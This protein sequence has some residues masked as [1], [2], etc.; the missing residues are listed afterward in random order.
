VRKRAPTLT[1]IAKTMGTSRPTV[2]QRIKRLAEF[3]WVER[4]VA[5]RTKELAG[6]WRPRDVFVVVLDHETTRR[7][8][9]A[10]AAQ[11]AAPEDALAE[12]AASALR[13]RE[14]L[15]RELEDA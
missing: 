9:A 10:A 2:Q 6:C 3:G 15:V 13:A 5:G 1:E 4:V 11:G 7:L 8:R 12:I 14:H